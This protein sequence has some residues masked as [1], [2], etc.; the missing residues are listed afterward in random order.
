MNMTDV[1]RTEIGKL[2][3]DGAVRKSAFDISQPDPK[4]RIYSWVSN[5]KMHT[6]IHKADNTTECKEMFSK[7]TEYYK[8]LTY[9]LAAGVV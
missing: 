5:K 8:P 9:L 6:N 1:M 4:S 3:G 7:Y 2:S